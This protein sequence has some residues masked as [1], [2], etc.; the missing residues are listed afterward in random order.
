ML[1]PPPVAFPSRS[2]SR[3]R[4][5]TPGRYSPN[6]VFSDA[7]LRGHPTIAQWVGEK[8]YSALQPSTLSKMV[9][10]P[11]AEARAQA[12]SRGWTEDAEGLHPP[13]KKSDTDFVVGMDAQL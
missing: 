9:G 2:R 7:L 6:L 11:D 13:L 12:I 3:S 4:S 10:L 8:A 5:P 1:R